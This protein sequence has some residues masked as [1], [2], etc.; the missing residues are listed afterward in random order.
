MYN[1]YTFIV[2]YVIQNSQRALYECVYFQHILRSN[3]TYQFLLDVE[4]MYL[5]VQKY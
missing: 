3:T 1:I 4:I 5:E 2:E